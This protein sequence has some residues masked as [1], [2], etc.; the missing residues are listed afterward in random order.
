MMREKT[1]RS[2]FIKDDLIITYSKP[3]IQPFREG[4][5]VN[6]DNEIMYFYYNIDILYKGNLV[7][8]SHTHDFPKINSL[9]N[10]I[11]YL[12]SD[13]GF[14]LENERG[15]EFGF[16]AKDYY[17]RVKHEDHFEME[18]GYVFEVERCIVKQHFETEY[19]TFDYYYMTISEP[20]MIMNRW[21]DKSENVKTSIKICM[22]KNDL[23][24]LK[25]VAESFMEASIEG[26]NSYDLPRYLEWLEE[27]P[28]Y[29]ED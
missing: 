5:L 11:D 26:Y 1:I 14:M 15:V 3:S 7:M 17:K 29:K 18:Y 2:T 22:T 8:H 12:L 28:E 25:K 19:Q 13:K 24:K 16:H 10:T 6:K 21:R 9:A 27:H 20:K 4:R 23:L